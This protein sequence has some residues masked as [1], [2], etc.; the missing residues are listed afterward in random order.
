[1]ETMMKVDVETLSTCKRAMR[2]EVPSERVTPCVEEVYRNL[3]R[4]ARL[5]GFRRGKVPRQILASR[6]REEIRDRVLRQM[7]PESYQEALTQV[8]LRPVNL[9]T[10]E[11]ISFEEG[12][13]LRYKA[14]VEVK[15]PIVVKDYKGIVVTRKPVAVKDEE[16]EEHL[17]QLREQSA[18]FVPMEGWPALRDDLVVADVQGFVGGKSVAILDRQNVTLAIGRGQLFPEVDEQLIGG[19]KGQVRE[20]P[21]DVPIDHPRREL[22]GKRVL[23][24]VVVKEIKKKRVPPLDDTFARE[25]GAGGSLRELRDKIREEL[26]GRKRQQ[27]DDRL[28]WE[29]VEQ[30]ASAQPFDLPESLVEMERE[31]ML[32][33]IARS[34]ASHRF[35]IQDEV[36]FRLKLDEAARRRV[37]HTLLLE[38]IACQEG[39]E[40]TPEEVDVELKAIAAVLQ[41]GVEGVRA[42]FEEEGRLAILRRQVRERKTLDML[43]VAAKIGEG[44]NLITVP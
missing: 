23:L 11:E 31:G 7:I 38:A 39:I 4:Q 17:A 1:M 32:Q 2:V 29:I 5:P 14:V 30:I 25:V 21:I 13:P 10:V 12:Q 18:E 43:F 33:E 41:Q 44:L 15:P 36:E 26:L 24:R 16:I 37:T 3:G 22:R 6:F 9:P 28:K 42:R 40:A 35:R 19:E 8:E 20:I 27:E 34:V